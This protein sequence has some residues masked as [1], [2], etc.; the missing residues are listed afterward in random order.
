MT[1]RT[2][3][4]RWYSAMLAIFSLCLCLTNCDGHNEVV[5]TG[6][7]GYILCTD[8]NVRT[9]E[10]M[11]ASGTEPIAVVFYGSAAS[12]ESDG[13]V[14]AVYLYD[15]EATQYAD[16]VGVSQGSSADITALDG[17]EN[18]YAIMSNTMVSSPMA[19]R[20]FEMWAY[21]QSGYIGSV[22]QYRLLYSNKSMVNKY[23]ELCGGDIL[24]DTA[25]DCW[26]WTSTEVSGAEAGQ[27]WLISMQ[28]G[29]IHE[30]PKTVYAKLRPIVTIYR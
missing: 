24:P 9:Y 29:A 2:N 25:A 11:A 20:V 5:D 12:D 19:D 27:A 28:N 21:G 7:V 1:K 6:E 3:P 16:S 13:D 18:T 22:A 30:T 26:Y 23:L 8:G 10:D 4:F 14:Y 15:L 17:K